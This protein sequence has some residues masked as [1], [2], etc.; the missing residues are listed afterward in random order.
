MS[1]ELEWSERLE[2]STASWLRVT[3]AVPG[4]ELHDD[5]DALW[6]VLPVSGWSNCGTLLRFTPDTVERR[7]D[8]IVNH[9]ADA[10]RANGFWVADCATPADLTTHL[11]ARNYRCRKRFPAM[12]CDLRQTPAAFE[13][14]NGVRIELVTDLSRF[15][16]KDPHPSIGPITTEIRR[17]QLE[18]DKHQ[19]AETPR[20]VFQFFA[21]EGDRAL[22]A[23]V[24][25][26]SDGVAGIHDVMVK[27][28]ERGRGIGTALVHACLT[29]GRNVGCDNAMLIS[30]G[31]GESLYRR[32]GFRE[33]CRIGYWYRG[34]ANL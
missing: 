28:T 11:R 27:E 1:E 25:L 8:E 6:I 4:V 16:P 34:L 12:A 33:V 29:Y 2:R 18:A 31:M 19:I 30:T 15:G 5:P 3:G 32:C 24:V 20:R 9:Y 7:L 17:F 22:G 14:S 21:W 23:A 13:P 26:A 10:G